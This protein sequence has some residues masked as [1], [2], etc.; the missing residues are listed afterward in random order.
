MYQIKLIRVQIL[1]FALMIARQAISGAMAVKLENLIF[2]N[3][4]NHAIKLNISDYN[5]PIIRL[6]PNTGC[7]ISQLSFLPNLA[8]DQNFYIMIKESSNYNAISIGAKHQLGLASDFGYKTAYSINNKFNLLAVCQGNV[9]KSPMSYV[10]FNSMGNVPHFVLNACTSSYY[11]VV[12]VNGKPNP[13]KIM[14]NFAKV[15]NIAFCD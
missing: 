3:M 6:N 8:F 12:T 15:K 2:Y 14:F 13:L 4:G 11:Y 9:L 1:I 10:S 7:K 5:N